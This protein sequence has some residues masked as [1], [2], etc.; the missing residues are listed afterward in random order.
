MSNVLDALEQLQWAT[1]AIAQ[2][3]AGQIALFPDFVVVADELALEW[4]SALRRI[5]LE[6]DAITGDQRAAIR[7]LDT[8]MSSISGR[9]NERFWT[10]EALRDAPEWRRMR[11]MAAD[12]AK[13]F[14]WPLAH[15]GPVSGF[16]IGRA[17]D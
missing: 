8:F 1:F 14:G 15:P 2:P 12:I 7:T 17:G 5:D 9:E 13:R 10:D 16:Y 4:E 6:G 11:D 3:A